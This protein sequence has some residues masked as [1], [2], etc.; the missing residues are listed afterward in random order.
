MLMETASKD[1]VRSDINSRRID[2][3]ILRNVEEK[4]DEKALVKTIA[5]DEISME[6]EWVGLVRHTDGNAWNGFSGDFS[7]VTENPFEGS[8]RI[9]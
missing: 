5:Y 6:S 8:V 4:M 7:Q 3:I 1:K 2:G 9:R